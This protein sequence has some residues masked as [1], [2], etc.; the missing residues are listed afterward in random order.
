MKSTVSRQTN[1]ISTLKTAHLQN[2]IS[3][4]RGE[5]QLYAANRRVDEQQE[6]I[7]ELYDLQDKLEQHKECHRVRIHP[8]DIE[9]RHK[10]NRKVNKPI[11]VK[12]VSHKTKPG[13]ARRES[14]WVT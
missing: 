10:L 5:K 4:E 2:I 13:Y 3:T 9:S 7:N 12:F 1:K 6:E 8:D 14:I 11:I